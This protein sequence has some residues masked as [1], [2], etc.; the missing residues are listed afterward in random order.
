LN[1]INENGITVVLAGG[2]SG[3]GHIQAAQNLK[4]SFKRIDP[5]IEVEL[6]NIFDYLP[7]SFRFVLEDLWKFSSLHLGFFYRFMHR[8]IV[9]NKYLSEIIKPR[10]ITSA[11]QLMPILAGKKMSVFIATHPAAAAVGAM[12]KRR[13]NFLFCVVATD[14]VLHNFHFYPEVDFYYLP[15]DST[16][17]GSIAYSDGFRKKSLVMG[18]PVSPA[19]WIEKDRVEL[20]KDFGLSPE[21]STVLISFGGNGLSADKHV[22]MLQALLK[23]PLPL[24]FIIIAGK[25][26]PFQKK[27]QALVSQENVSG[28]VKVFGFVDKMENIADLMTVSDLFI[29]KAGGVSLSE[30]LAKR[31]PVG[32]LEPL[33]GPEDYNTTFIV[34]NKLGRRVN[35]QVELA[36]W[37]RSLLFSKVLSDWKNRIGQFGRPFSGRDIA[38]HVIERIRNERKSHGFISYENSEPDDTKLTDL[39][40]SQCLTGLY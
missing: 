36:Q 11:N 7:P 31:L 20:S 37:I 33:P 25:N 39:S 38:C 24:Q 5:F 14:F 28:R 9:K 18:I 35:N 23:L 30:A 17:M 3:L 22:N 32:I 12:L 26:R 6:I 19:F 10:F 27:L 4:D 13:L 40:V 15:P 8:V 1:K 21:T 29:G 16:L 34:R 2:S